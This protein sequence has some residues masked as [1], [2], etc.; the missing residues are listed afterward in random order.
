MLLVRF[1]I[2]FLLSFFCCFSCDD[3]RPTLHLVFLTYLKNF[4]V[5]YLRFIQ[6]YVIII[7]YL[8]LRIR[9]SF[10]F[11]I[12]TSCV[13]QFLNERRKWHKIR[14]H[15][16]PYEKKHLPR[17]WRQISGTNC[18]WNLTSTSCDMH[19]PTDHHELIWVTEVMANDISVTSSNKNTKQWL[20]LRLLP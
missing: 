5:L 18:T 20:V 17:R 4:T 6:V 15:D 9:M 11:L 8:T 7:K 10:S 2:F 1:K 16:D 3:W 12:N 14:I 13:S 19:F